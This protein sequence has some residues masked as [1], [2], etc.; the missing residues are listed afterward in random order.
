MRGKDGLNTEHKVS[1]RKDWYKY[2]K[3]SNR[4]VCK[5]LLDAGSSKLFMFKMF[6]LNCPS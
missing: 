6:Y 3:V 4:I 1:I 2:G 5:I